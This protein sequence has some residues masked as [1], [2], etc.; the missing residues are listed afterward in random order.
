MSNSEA[1]KICSKP[2]QWVPIDIYL[3]IFISYTPSFILGKLF[4]DR[5]WFNLT[6]LLYFKISQRI[7]QHQKPWPALII[8]SLALIMP[9]PI[10]HFPN[11]LATN[12]PNNILRNHPFCTFASFL[13]VSLTTFINTPDS[14]TDFTIF[15]V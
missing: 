2:I 7:K 4:L 13:I 3:S 1:A 15:M 6:L 11:K 10:Y 12:L 9:L 5:F 8:S 14:S